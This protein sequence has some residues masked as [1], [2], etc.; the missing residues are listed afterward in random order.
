[1]LL[2]LTLAVLLIVIAK[3]SGLENVGEAVAF[4]VILFIL[5]MGVFQYL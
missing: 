3:E 5:L 4:A 1:M 2:Y